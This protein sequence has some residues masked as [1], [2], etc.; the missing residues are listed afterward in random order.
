MWHFNNTIQ[1]LGCDEHADARCPCYYNTSSSA[2]TYNV[3]AVQC[4]GVCNVQ[5]RWAMLASLQ[6]F[7]IVYACSMCTI[8][9]CR[10][11]YHW[12]IFCA[13]P[14][15]ATGLKARQ[16]REQQVSIPVHHTCMLNNG[17]CSDVLTCWWTTCPSSCQQLATP[18]CNPASTNGANQD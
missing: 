13:Q 16:S 6:P 17:V 14:R 11:A 7:S 12:H 18:V 9:A 5:C 8:P 2:Y 4:S 15:P 3:A 1:L 10:R